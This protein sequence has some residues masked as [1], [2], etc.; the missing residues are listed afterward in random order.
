VSTLNKK[1]NSK[2]LASLF[3]LGLVMVAAPSLAQGNSNGNANGNANGKNDGGKV[4]EK[5]AQQLYNACRKEADA[6][7][8]ASGA[9][10]TGLGSSDAIWGCVVPLKAS[11]NEDKKVCQD[12]KDSRRAACD[13]LGGGTY[14]GWAEVEFQQPSEG[15][16]IDGNDFLP[17]IPGVTEYSTDTSLI[18]RE[19]TDITREVDGVECLLVIESETDA[20]AQLV[21]RRELLYAEDIENNIWNCG[22]L[23]QQYEVLDEGQDA[24]V[25]GIEGSW[26]AGVAGTLPGMAMP[27]APLAG[28]VYRAAFAPGLLEDLVEVI[29]PAT[30]EPSIPC[31]VDCTLL[32]VTSP[33]FEGYRDEYYRTLEGLVRSED[34]DGGSVVEVAAPVAP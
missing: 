18:S 12:E 9:L 4:C 13:S 24:V 20:N 21:E 30:I 5:Q 17:L 27:A 7:R 25:T 33:L 14:S 11:F 26:Q 15:G 32:R 6:T 23:M 16:L 29:D 10:C 3:S 2:L 28:T 34:Q 19:V 1:T 22:A 8:W 31:D